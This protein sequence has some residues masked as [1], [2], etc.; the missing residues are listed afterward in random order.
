M[1]PHSD[2]CTS[3][4]SVSVPL[5]YLFLHAPPPCHSPPQAR[6]L[7]GQTLLQQD[8]VE[9]KVD[10][11]L[12]LVYRQHLDNAAPPVSTAQCGISITLTRQS[13]VRV[14]VCMHA[15]VCVCMCVD[16]MQLLQC[17]STP[18][19]CVSVKLFCDWPCTVCLQNPRM[20]QPLAD[21]YFL[22]VME[23]MLSEEM[24]N[25]RLETALNKITDVSK[26]CEWK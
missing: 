23:H 3:T 2:L 14:C 18:V 12:P 10:C 24:V 26:V 20:E 5:L 1:Y 11:Y 9:G 25:M 13:S 7:V 8:R 15:R 6:S 21:V 19:V 22:V 4:I 17:V 16:I